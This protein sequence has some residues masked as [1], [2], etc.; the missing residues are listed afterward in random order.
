MT[1]VQDLTAFA[2]EHLFDRLNGAFTESNA[3][4]REIE[5]SRGRHD[6]DTYRDAIEMIIEGESVPVVAERTGIRANRVSRI[7]RAVNSG[8]LK[9]YRDLAPE[10]LNYLIEGSKYESHR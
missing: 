6:L 10:Y 1:D 4:A 7:A 9:R 8:A 3:R 2:R 5:E